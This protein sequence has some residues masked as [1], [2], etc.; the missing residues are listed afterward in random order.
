MRVNS[1]RAN[2]PGPSDISGGTS[3]RPPAVVPAPAVPSRNVPPGVRGLSS[4]RRG[5]L[6]LRRWWSTLA[7]VLLWQLIAAL[8]LVPEVVLP[9]PSDL[10]VTALGML[11]DGSL[12]HALLVSLARVTAGSALGLLIGLTFGLLA[13]LS[14]LGEDIIDRPLQALRTIPFT[15][16]APLFILWFGLGET[17]KILL[18]AVATL[19]PTYLNTSAGVRGVDARLV[20]MARAYNVRRARIVYRVVLLGALPSVLTGVRFALGLAWVAVIIAETINASEG[21]GFLLTNARTYVR[22]DI[23]MVCIAVYAGLGLFTDAIVRALESH[24]LRWRT[25]HRRN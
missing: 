3:A 23:V 12:L 21:L 9:G 20:E 10:V 18:V 5:R 24:L 17:P 19:I 16:L 15:A 13:G 1:P 2:P 25:P 11:G 8:R 7:I 6:V 4:R 14:S 22:T